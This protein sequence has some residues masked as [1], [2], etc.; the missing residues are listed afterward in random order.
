MSKEI[1][2]ESKI[3]HYFTDCLVC[4]HCGNKDSDSWAYSDEDGVA[5]CG[6]CGKEYYYVRHTT[7]KYSTEKERKVLPLKVRD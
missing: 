2:K 3:D 6:E 7:V 5:S 1:V 4:P